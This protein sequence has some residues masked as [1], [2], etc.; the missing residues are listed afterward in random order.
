M[1]LSMRQ[2]VK[3]VATFT[4]HRWQRPGTLEVTLRTALREWE[5]NEVW[6]ETTSTFTT[7]RPRWPV[8]IYAQLLHALRALPRD[9]DEGIQGHFVHAPL[10]GE[11]AFKACMHYFGDDDRGFHHFIYRDAFLKRFFFVK[12]VPGAIPTKNGA[13]VE[14]TV[15]LVWEIVRSSLSTDIDKTS[16][17]TRRIFPEK[18]IPAFLG[19]AGSRCPKE[20][21]SVHFSKMLTWFHT[22]FFM[23]T[24]GLSTS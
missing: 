18:I 20:K 21:Q 10:A 13:F 23:T 19:Y 11:K 3:F 22:F 9:D 14:E 15:R 12:C 16:V 6:N 2:K 24:M 1:V 5:G 8:T 7:S 17:C 4:R